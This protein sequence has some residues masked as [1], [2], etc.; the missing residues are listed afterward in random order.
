MA[1]PST[2]EISPKG[3]MLN[4][5]KAMRTLQRFVDAADDDEPVVLQPPPSEIP[6]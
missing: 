2:L 6:E 3:K 5:N 4:E 1:F